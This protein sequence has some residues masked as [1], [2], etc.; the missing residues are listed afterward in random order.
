MVL[1]QYPFDFHLLSTNTMGFVPVDLCLTYPSALKTN[2][3]NSF[4]F[5]PPAR[6][7]LL[8]LE[9]TRV[10]GLEM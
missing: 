8:G 7:I 6:P 4:E 5:T 1:I 2:L 9:E 3:C 10:S